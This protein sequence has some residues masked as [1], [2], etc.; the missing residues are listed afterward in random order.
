MQ[1]FSSEVVTPTAIGK[2]GKRAAAF[3]GAAVVASYLIMVL[4]QYFKTESLF[5]GYTVDMEKVESILKQTGYY[6]QWLKQDKALYTVQELIE[7]RIKESSPEE[8]YEPW[9]IAWTGEMYYISKKADGQYFYFAFCNNANGQSA[10]N[11]RFRC[12]VRKNAVLKAT[13]PKEGEVVTIVGYTADNSL[14]APRIKVLGVLP[15]NKE[16]TN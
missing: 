3:A 14:G 11:G 13:N 6:E 12:Y 9:I 4:P 8:D 10:G 15:Y 1:F 16:A 2:W 7:K 5:A